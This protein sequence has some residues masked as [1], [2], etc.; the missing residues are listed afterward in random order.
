MSSGPMRRAVN[1]TV[2]AAVA[3]GRVDRALDAALIETARALADQLDAALSSGD[4][5]RVDKAVFATPHLVNALRELGATP[6]LRAELDRAA[7]RGEA[8]SG[9][10]ARLRAVAGGKT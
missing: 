9:A 10:V 1:R 3:E 5:A 6:R 2:R 7:R 8:A 4:A